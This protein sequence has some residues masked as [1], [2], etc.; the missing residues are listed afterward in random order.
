MWTLVIVTAL[1]SMNSIPT[2]QIFPYER[3]EDCTRVRNAIEQMTTF[4]IKVKCV[5]PEDS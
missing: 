2:V 1:A 4:N 5:G 3:K